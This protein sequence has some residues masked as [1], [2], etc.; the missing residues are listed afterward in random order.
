MDV[1]LIGLGLILAGGLL[2]PALSRAPA[3]GT[4]VAVSAMVGG[5]AVGLVPAAGVLAGNPPLGM[6]H[7]WDG[8]HGPAAVG[9]DALSAFFLVPTLV[10]AALAAVYGGSY[11]SGSFPRR[12]LGP[13]W[14]FFNMF[15]G[16]MVLV[17]IAR[18][19]VQFLV[20]WEVMSLSAFFLV[21]FEH[22]HREARQAGWVYLVATHL[23][24]AF[25]IALF[26]LLGRH[27]GGIEFAD[28]RGAPPPAP[29]A[30][31]PLLLL[32]VAGFGAKAGLVP[33]HVWLPEA[34]AAAPS[35]VS[36]LMS[37]VMIKMGVYG[38]LRTVTF[39]G[40]PEPWWGLTLG[41]LGFLTAVLGIA[42]ACYQRDIKRVL[43]Y[44]SIEN[45]GLIV[46][47]LGVGLWGAATGRPAVAALGLTAGL[48]HVWNHAAMKGLMFFAAGS[49]LHG[50]G[51]RDMERLGGL[52]KRM[53]WTGAAMIVGAVA[54]A[55][56]PPLNG[57]A[58]KWLT[59]LGL[60]E[61]ALTPAPDHGLVALTLVGFLA[62]VGGL[63]AVTFVR[64][65]GI[66][67]LGT[68]RGEAARD[69]H[70]SSWWMLGPMVILAFGCLAAGLFP[71]RVA[72]LLTTA[73]DQIWVAPPG[74]TDAEAS[75]A[76]L[77]A[78]NAWV[79]V[80]LGAAA[81]AL[82]LLTRRAAA[83]PTWG[84][85]YAAPS[86][87]MQYTGRSFAEMLAGRVF[88]R[89]FRPKIHRKP[90]EGL[91]PSLS[92]FTSECDDPVRAKVYDPFF[93]RWADRFLRLRV[94]QHGK[95]HVY[96]LYILA[97]VVAALAWATVRTWTWRAP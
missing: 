17:L 7:D 81:G 63:S 96:L 49:V 4:A 92:A 45:V 6:Q 55:A 44:S 9:L 3:L 74:A 82:A 32:A 28:F 67:L 34:H 14:F 11:L 80:A 24:V 71:D 31:G 10:L 23:G 88:P 93:A 46:L 62:L 95:V 25:L 86:P 13:A 12:S 58:G 26:A 22:E 83:G 8:L 40:P 15:V 77:G 5:C 21:C 2:A 42:L 39:L 59:Y 48:L 69:A 1:L 68:P 84:C 36:A 85:G 47:A 43:A 30:A 41:G 61:C 66:T 70:E 91:F 94:L 38:L 20:A 50:A 29:L 89:P 56:L 37:G 76:R 65:C 79:V 19:A 27:A 57:F 18:T 60:M 51:G 54:I 73:R 87:R 16:G 52:L 78:F 64:L 72:G 75:L 53:P 35:H 90:V 97:T 33:A